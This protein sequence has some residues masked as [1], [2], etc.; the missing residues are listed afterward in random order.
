MLVLLEFLKK[1]Q[2]N[3]ALNFKQ[4]LRNVIIKQLQ[5]KNPKVRRF[6]VLE[7]DFSLNIL[8]KLQMYL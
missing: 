4:R 3:Q 5:I 1:E 7:S 6:L 8:N 2:M